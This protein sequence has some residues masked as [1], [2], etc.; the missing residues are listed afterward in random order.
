MRPL[1]LAAALLVA[2]GCANTARTADPL[3]DFDT[4]DADRDGFVT[5]AEF[6]V[7]FAQ[8]PYYRGYD[9]DRD[10]VLNRNEF[11]TGTAAYGY[12]YDAFDL[13]RDGFVNDREYSGRRLPRVRRRPRRGPRSE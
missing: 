8:A 11:G 10:G 12:D 3:Y 2:A 4:Y 6:G 7:G 13:D 9:T 1:L 5:D